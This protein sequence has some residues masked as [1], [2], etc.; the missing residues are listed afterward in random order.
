M[1]RFNYEYGQRSQEGPISEHLRNHVSENSSTPPHQEQV[2]VMDAPPYTKEAIN[3]FQ[4]NALWHL[5]EKNPQGIFDHAL[6]FARASLGTDDGDGKLAR[7]LE[8]HTNS[9]VRQIELESKNAGTTLPQVF[10]DRYENDVRSCILT[11]QTRAKPSN[12]LENPVNDP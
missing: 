1:A 3:I 11:A 10:L 9:A 5:D 4:D 6:R 8:V 7:Y 12:E 2:G